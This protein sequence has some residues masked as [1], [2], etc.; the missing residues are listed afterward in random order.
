MDLGEQMT[1]KSLS[2]MGLLVSVAAAAVFTGNVIAQEAPQVRTQDLGHGIYALYGRGGTIGLSVGDDGVFLIDDQVGAVAEP[3]QTA[4]EELAG[5]P[6][7][8]VLNTHWHGDHTGNEP[9]AE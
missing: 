4:I 2:A 7:T 6:V 1:F 8:Y 3:L 5:V 9:A